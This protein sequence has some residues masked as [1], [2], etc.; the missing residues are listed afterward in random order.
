[1][2]IRTTRGTWERLCYTYELPWNVYESGPLLGKSKNN[3][4]RIK[5]GIYDLKPRSD[6][7]KGWR[8]ELQNTGHR[9]NIQIHRAHSSLFIEGCILPLNFNDLS[10]SKLKK[11][12]PLIQ[13]QSTA[14]MNNIKSRYEKIKTG[15]KVIHP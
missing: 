2:F 8:L 6:G 12:G 13:A 14:L 3:L 11:G 1:M 10:A 5:I 15:K 7:P 4:S 9:S